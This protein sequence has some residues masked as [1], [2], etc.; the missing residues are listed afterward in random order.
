M[1]VDFAYLKEAMS[2]LG[3]WFNHFRLCYDLHRTAVLTHGSLSQADFLTRMGIKVRVEALKRSATDETR[4]SDIDKAATRLV[5]LTGMGNQY[6]ILGITS[7]VDP[8]TPPAE[9]IW[10]FVSAKS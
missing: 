6:R 4:R 3:K 2:Y 8:A 7:A 10:P 1:N 5:D 9:E